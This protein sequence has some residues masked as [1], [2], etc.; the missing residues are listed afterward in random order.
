MIFQSNE[1][2]NAMLPGPLHLLL[3][4]Q[5]WMLL[6]EEVMW[7][8]NVPGRHG[9]QETSCG[10]GYEWSQTRGKLPAGKKVP[11]NEMLSHGAK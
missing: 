9:L 10:P 3:G 5:L 1:E 4:V 7:D 11:S 2:L 6:V 8:M